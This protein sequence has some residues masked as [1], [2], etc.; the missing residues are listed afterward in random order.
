VQVYS[1]FTGILA[2]QMKKAMTNNGAK[3]GLW[4]V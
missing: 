1:S 3:I 4:G 2:A